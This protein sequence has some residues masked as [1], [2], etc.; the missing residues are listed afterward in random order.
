MKDYL[1]F[2]L[3]ALFP[4]ILVAQ[5]PTKLPSSAKEINALL[6]KRWSLAEIEAY[7]TPE[8]RF[9]PGVQNLVMDGK[10]VLKGKLYEG[11]KSSFDKIDWYA[12][13]N[14]SSIE[15]SLNVF[16]GRDHWLLE[17]GNEESL[18]QPL[19]KLKNAKK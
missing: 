19:K 6:E 1:A 7:C 11:Q 9:P 3:I 17:I 10:V 5:E 2:F 4:L 16:K 13:L 14:T 15:Y 12:N 18:H 8:N